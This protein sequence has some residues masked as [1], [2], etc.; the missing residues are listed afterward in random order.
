MNTRT[1][2]ACAKAVRTVSPTSP[3]EDM[4]RQLRK[5]AI[6]HRLKDDDVVELF[7]HY[8][9]FYHIDADVGPPVAILRSGRHVHDEY[10]GNDMRND[11]VLLEQIRRAVVLD[12]IQSRQRKEGD[13]SFTKLFAEVAQEVWHLQ[14]TLHESVIRDLFDDLLFESVQRSLFEFLKETYPDLDIGLSTQEVLADVLSHIRQ[15]NVLILGRDA[16][17]ARERLAR[18]REFVEQHGYRGILVREQPEDVEMGLISK[19]LLYV[20]LSRFVVVENSDPS[21]HLYE[22][23]Y[24]RGTE[25]VIGLLQQRNVGATRMFDDMLK[26]HPLCKRFYYTD[27]SLGATVGKLVEWAEKR[28]ATNAEANREAW[29]WY[30]EPRVA[31]RVFHPFEHPGEEA[32]RGPGAGR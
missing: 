32:G 20:L 28:I 7:R 9:S 2:N 1:S 4:V 21:G 14:Q 22:L 17:R 29:P 25:S 5:I 12:C 18:I 11:G 13:P 16:G 6:Q 3:P 31:S 8:L 26:K 15:N 24:V 27:R 19:V 30:R 23:P 10:D